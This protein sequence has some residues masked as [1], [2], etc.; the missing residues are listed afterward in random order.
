MVLGPEPVSVAVSATVAEGEN[1][2]VHEP[3]LQVAAVVGATL[4]GVTVNCV[5]SE[6]PPEFDAVTPN[7]PVWLLAE[8]QE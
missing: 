8:P 4:S 2:P 7:D 6:L 5:G 1:E 3:P